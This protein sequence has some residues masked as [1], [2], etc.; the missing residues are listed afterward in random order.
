MTSFCRIFLRTPPVLCPLPVGLTGC[1]ANGDE[2][3]GAASQPPLLNAVAPALPQTGDDAPPP[4]KTGGFDGKRAFAH[5][6]RQVSFGPHASGSAAIAQVQNY[7]LSELKSYGCSVERSEEHTSEL[8][9]HSDLVCRLL[10][11]K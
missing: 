11:E 3:P 4:E 9:S 10:L 7:L 8:Q 2:P 5:V 6:A 1:K